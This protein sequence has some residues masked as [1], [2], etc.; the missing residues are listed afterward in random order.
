M[1]LPRTEILVVIPV[2][3]TM[4]HQQVIGT[5]FGQKP[6][7]PHALSH[8][9]YSAASLSKQCISGACASTTL[10]D[11]PP[12]TTLLHMAMKSLTPCK[13]AQHIHAALIPRRLNTAAHS[14]KG[15]WDPNSL[16]TLQSPS[17]PSHT[18]I[19]ANALL[20]KLGAMYVNPS[21]ALSRLG[22]VGVPQGLSTGF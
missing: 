18:P 7:P 20:M 6:C 12:M 14:A 19:P 15:T 17:F 10:L 9:G 21:N 2:L 8:R 13:M 11:L 1:P 5:I 4:C 3:A 16:P 22:S